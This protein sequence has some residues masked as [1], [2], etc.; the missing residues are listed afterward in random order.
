MRTRNFIGLIMV[1]SIATYLYV[2]ID[3]ISDVEAVCALFP[4][5][6]AVGNLK[7]IESEYSVRYM[8]SFEFGDDPGT[9]RAVFCASLAMCDNS[10]NVEYRNDTVIKSHV[11]SL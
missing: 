8:G 10:C 11:S 4:A 7:A 9:Q 6:A 3:Q 1:A 5:G 2:M